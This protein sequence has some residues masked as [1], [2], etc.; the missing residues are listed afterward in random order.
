[1][2]EVSFKA[3]GTEPRKDYREDDT[4]GKA[5]PTGNAGLR[6]LNHTREMRHRLMASRMPS[7]RE[8]RSS[9]FLCSNALPVWF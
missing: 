8:L 6:A 9:S 3:S 4:S 5:S 1:M 7:L 2:L